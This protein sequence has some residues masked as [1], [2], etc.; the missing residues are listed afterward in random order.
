MH[1]TQ[2]PK[3]KEKV[4]AARRQAAETRRKRRKGTIAKGV[5]PEVPPQSVKALTASPDPSGEVQ[6]ILDIIVRIGKLSPLGRQ[7]LLLAVI[8]GD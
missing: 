5:A 2:R 6:A 8:G 4:A 1:W 7:Y 3:N